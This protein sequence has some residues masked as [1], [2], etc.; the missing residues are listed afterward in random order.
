[1]GPPDLVSWLRL[2][3]RLPLPRPLLGLEQLLV[4]L[5]PEVQ[6][7][8]RLLRSSRRQRQA[9]QGHQED[10]PEERHHRRL[11]C[12]QDHQDQ[13]LRCPRHRH[14]RA[15]DR[16]D[17]LHQGTLVL[18]QPCHHLQEVLA[19][20]PGRPRRH[21]QRQQVRCCLQ[22][23]QPLHQARQPRLQRERPHLQRPAC[24]SLPQRKLSDLCHFLVIHIYLCYK[25]NMY[26][27]KKKKKHPKKKKKKKKKKK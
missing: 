22:Q 11:R 18:R 12:H 27:Q 1:M 9:C 14:Q 4:S 25:R 13:V 23:Q 24:C 6:R 21:R 2:P 7:R 17:Q 20:C 10:L 15:H 16:Q 5:R 3:R 19:C 8:L 26:R